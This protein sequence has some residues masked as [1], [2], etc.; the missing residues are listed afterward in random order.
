MKAKMTGYQDGGKMPADSKKQ[1]L[2]RKLF[3]SIPKFNKEEA[4]RGM[5]AEKINK[6]QK[7][8]DYW[9]KKGEPT[10]ASGV[11]VQMDKIRE[12][13]KK[14]AGGGKMDMYSKG[15][16]LKKRGLPEDNKNYV[17]AE[18]NRGVVKVDSE[19][20]RTVKDGKTEYVSV[21]NISDAAGKSQRIVSNKDGESST[22]FA[23]K[24]YPTQPVKVGP[25][26]PGKIMANINGRGYSNIEK[27]V[28]PGISNSQSVSDLEKAKKMMYRY[29]GKMKKYLMGGQVKLDKNKDGKI[30]AV[31]F[32]MLKKK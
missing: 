11:K 32:K 28:R 23:R 10:T 1:E 2:A 17:G 30:S 18:P 25:S 27:D 7:E 31:D 26:S 20:T 22:A 4:R 24:S 29:G 19:S 9:T 12:D 5:M 8:Y 14:Y 13:M 15:G 6:L 3:G 21:T 16:K